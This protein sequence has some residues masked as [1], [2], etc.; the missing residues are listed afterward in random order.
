MFSNVLTFVCD[1]G[2]EISGS[3]ISKCQ[4]N[5]LWSSPSVHCSGKFDTVLAT[6]VFFNLYLSAVDCGNL[7]DIRNGRKIG[8]ANTTLGFEVMFECNPCYEL[9]GSTTRTCQAN[10]TWSGTEPSCNSV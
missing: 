7:D 6:E 9:E 8:T 1:E 10:S 5:G 4:A 3:S 2:Y